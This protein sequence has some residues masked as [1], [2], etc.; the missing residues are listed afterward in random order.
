M[1]YGTI[2]QRSMW[3]IKRLQGTQLLNFNHLLYIATILYIL[4]EGQKNR[5]RSI[6]SDSYRKLKKNLLNQLNQPFMKECQ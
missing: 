6:P 2:R 4:T 3:Y 5:S 1:K